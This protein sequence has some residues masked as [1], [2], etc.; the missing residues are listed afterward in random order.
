MYV[1]GPTVY[2]EIHVGNARPVLVFDLLYRVLKHVYADVIYTSNITDIDDKI[3][4]KAN[5]EG[6]S[7]KDVATLWE[8]SFHANC[9]KLNTL[10]PTFQPRASECIKEIIESVGELIESGF[11]YCKDG[12]VL[13]RISEVAE[14]G[15]LSK[16][17]GVISGARITS[18]IDKE[19]EKDFVLWKPSKL[20]EPYWNS[21]WGK[22]RPGWHI[23]C[24]A[25]S[26]KYLGQRFDI[27]GG[28]QDLI[29]PHHENEQAQNI[30]L[31]GQYAGPR[32]WMHN[33]MVLFDGEKMSKSLGN[34]VLLSQAFQKY[35]PLLVRFFILSTHYRHALLWKDESIQQAHSRLQRWL[36][37]LQ[38]Q[39]DG[40]HVD[41]DVL[42]ALKN[43]L[44][45]PEAFAIVDEKLSQ[46][47][48]EE[49]KE[50]LK[51]LANTLKWL[52]LLSDEDQELQ[53]LLNEKLHQRNLAR[54]T[55]DY[56]L[57]DKLRAEIQVHGY[58][59][60]DSDSGSILKK[61]L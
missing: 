34:V 29:F 48:K 54:Q 10:P 52:G 17:T 18:Y 6:K 36:C 11:A 50:M 25:M 38:G 20:G 57:A 53:K 30:G 31:Y 24:S 33:A 42:E 3:I 37:H 32:Y 55:K 2:N 40:G 1:C 51:K 44:N 39:T 14:Y 47:L 19:D 46:A 7:A 43:D 21:P 59:V 28:G 4:K 56:L 22:G 8:D 13:F 27:H 58:D 5:E 9:I 12:N 61:I 60:M 35:D 45:T 23:E 49:D 16:Q 41:D 15:K 26:A